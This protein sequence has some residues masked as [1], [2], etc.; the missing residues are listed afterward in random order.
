MANIFEDEESENI[1]NHGVGLLSWVGKNLIP[2]QYATLN[3]V[4]CA[5]CLKFDMYEFNPDVHACFEPD[6]KSI[7]GEW[8]CEECTKEQGT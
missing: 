1:Y 5:K 3:L 7:D 8:V 2:G 4:R 6:W